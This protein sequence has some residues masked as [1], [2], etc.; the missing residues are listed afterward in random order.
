MFNSMNNF[1]TF[2]LL[3]LCFIGFFSC[4]EEKILSFSEIH[5]SKE[6]ETF[7]DIVM[8]KA[9]GNSNVAKNI[10]T[11]LNNFAC[12]ILNVDSAKEKK[13]TIDQSITAFNASYIGFTTLFNE[14]IAR[15]FPKWEAFIDGEISFQNEFIICIAMNGNV[16][17]G[18]A[19]SNLIFKFFNFD[20]ATG[21]ELKT[22]D[23]INDLNGFKA[24]VKKYYDKE[25]MT[26]HNGLQSQNL[27]FKL[28]ET[29]GFN[30]EGIIIFYNNFEFGAL[31]K[32]PVEF[33]IP[34]VVANSYLKF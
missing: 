19:N 21:K 27:D 32:E 13:L 4:E 9:K 11:S 22:K 31:S 14:D 26:V 1:R 25:L 24:L 20:P 33:T 18:E 10:N 15:D 34:Y 6:K 5:I 12:D 16:Q 23:L 7:V 8:P 30:E 3:F 28:P 2:Y 29:I 17:T